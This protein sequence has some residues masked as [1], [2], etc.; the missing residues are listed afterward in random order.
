MPILDKRGFKELFDL[1]FQALRDYVYYRCGDTE[2]ATDIAQD[3]FMKIWEKRDNVYDRIEM[4]LL[5][6]MANDMVISNYRKVK[7]GQKFKNAI[8]KIHMDTI[9]PEERL[10]FKELNGRYERA[11]NE[12]NANERVVFL[13]NR[14]QGLKYAEIAERI[15]ISIKAV[16]KRMSKALTYLRV[17]LM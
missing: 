6:K 8:P 4:G 7:T 1:N 15:G 2:L 17:Q 13:M 3:V 12:L 9:T 11:I 5:I 10:I 14:V 16:E